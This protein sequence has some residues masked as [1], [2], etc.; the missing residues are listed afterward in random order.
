MKS[1][2][3]Q[4]KYKNCLLF[5]SVN[6]GLQERNTHHMEKEKCLQNSKSYVKNIFISNYF[7][8]L[9]IFNLN[10]KKPSV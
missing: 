4:W 7:K 9:L 1:P 5:D 6:S 10:K 2:F 8:C 3:N